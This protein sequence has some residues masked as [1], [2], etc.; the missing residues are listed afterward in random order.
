MIRQSPWS[1][2]TGRI[3]LKEIQFASKKKTPGGQAPWGAAK[4]FVRNVD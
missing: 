2:S 1:C 4:I 3:R